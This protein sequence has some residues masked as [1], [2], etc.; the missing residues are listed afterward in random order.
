MELHH[1][2]RMNFRGWDFTD[3]FNLEGITE[4]IR[5]RKIIKPPQHFI[6]IA[7]THNRGLYPGGTCYAAVW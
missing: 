6:R 3:I 7:M 4:I 2:F 5:A 1:A